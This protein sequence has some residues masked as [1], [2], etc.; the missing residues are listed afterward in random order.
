MYPCLRISKHMYVY[1]RKRTCMYACVFIPIYALNMHLN[2]ILSHFMYMNVIVGNIR[3][4][5]RIIGL[6]S[7]F[8][9]FTSDS[10]KAIFAADARPRHTRT[11]TPQFIV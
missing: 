11:E 5:V 2:V 10:A 1:V 8:K 6:H 3:I 7:G 9:M 4:L